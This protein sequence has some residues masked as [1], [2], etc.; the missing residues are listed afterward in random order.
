MTRTKQNHPARRDLL[1][2]SFGFS[3]AITSVLVLLVATYAL[4]IWQARWGYFFVLIFT[5]ALP[6]LLEPIKSPAAVW[7]AFFLSIFP[8]CATGMQGFGQTKRNWQSV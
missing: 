6:R 8:F 5:L 1:E 2:I 7:I 4:T 3:D